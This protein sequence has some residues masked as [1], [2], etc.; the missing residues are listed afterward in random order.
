MH[1]IL[2]FLLIFFSK[3][4]GDNFIVSS[5][6]SEKITFEPQYKLA[7]ADETN[8][9]GDKIVLCFEFKFKALQERCR[10]AVQLETKTAY[11]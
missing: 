5:F 11:F 9:I 1:F 3:P 4:S 2:F 6:I 7:F 10:P 8:V